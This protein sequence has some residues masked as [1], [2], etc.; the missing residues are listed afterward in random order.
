MTTLHMNLYLDLDTVLEMVCIVLALLGVAIGAVAWQASRRLR[1]R[2]GAL[3]SSL[4]AMR[5]ELELAAAISVRAGRSVKRL[6]QEHASVAD[7]LGL[8]E[9]RCEARPYDQAI[10]S[11]RRGADP[12]KL[13]AQFGLSRGEAD[14]VSRL[15]GRRKSA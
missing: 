4:A 11:A 6:E 5:H 10:D 7:R 9:L 2:C 14:L 8:L 12:L 15:H 3:E 13:T 1:T